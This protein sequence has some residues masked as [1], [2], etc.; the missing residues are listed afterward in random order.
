[1]ALAGVG[2]RLLGVPQSITLRDGRRF[3][4]F[5]ELP[6]G[7]ADG[8]ESRAARRI[9]R[10]ERFSPVKAVTLVILL[11]LDVLGLRAGVPVAA[12][13]AIPERLEAEVG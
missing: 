3:V 5:A 8:I 12:D 1:M 9:A 4:P 2:D 13:F 6:S 10:L 7:F 11:V